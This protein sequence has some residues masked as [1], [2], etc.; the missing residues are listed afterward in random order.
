MTEVLDL[1]RVT[2]AWWRET[3]GSVAD[4]DVL[5]PLAVVLIVGKGLS[6]T[7]VLLP[8]EL[9]YLLGAW[10]YR[11]PLAVQPLK[12][13]AVAIAA[14]II[15]SSALIVGVLFLMLEVIG[16]VSP[17]GRAVVGGVLVHVVLDRAQEQGVTPDQGTPGPGEVGRVGAVPALGDVGQRRLRNARRCACRRSGSSVRPAACHDPDRRSRPIP[18]PPRPPG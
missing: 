16:F 10:V 12:A 13:E 5:E 14:G 9:T 3:S 8:V 6:A 7:A 15:A 4:L 17:L 1:P 2:W 18:W 11:V